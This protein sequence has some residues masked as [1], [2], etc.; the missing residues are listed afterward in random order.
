M[1]LW[2]GQANRVFK[3]HETNVSCLAFSSDSEMIVSG[4]DDGTVRLWDLHGQPIGPQFNGHAAITS[5]ALS[6]DGNTLVSGD[7]SGKI[8]VRQIGIETFLREA[9]DWLRY[10][11]AL[12]S[13]ETEKEK[14][15]AEIARSLLKS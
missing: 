13:P 9:C 7:K 11:R 8:M 14:R 10:H 4:A 12:L 15:A 3:G 1:R 2:D 5:V 6:P